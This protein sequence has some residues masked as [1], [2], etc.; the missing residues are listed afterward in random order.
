MNS[1]V[2]SHFKVFVGALAEDRTPGP[3]AAEVAAWAKASGVAAKSIGVEYL[4]GAGKLLLTVGYRDDE[5]GYPVALR[6]V[7]LGRI[8]GLDEAGRAALE[9]RMAAASARLSS[10]LC[11][12][13]YVTADH[14][15]I[16]TFLVQE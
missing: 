2:H 15:V 16:M 8:E 11:H 1:Q 10:I 6:S 7:S 5:P 14:E 9:Q 12:E 4:E 3:L 13:L